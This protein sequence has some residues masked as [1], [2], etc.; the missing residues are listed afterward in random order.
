MDEI[1]KSEFN[2]FVTKFQSYFPDPQKP[3]KK[4]LAEPTQDEINELIAEILWRL[5]SPRDA[6][7]HHYYFL[8]R[9]IAHRSDCD[10]LK[11]YIASI[12]IWKC[13]SRPEKCTWE[14]HGRRTTSDGT[15]IYTCCCGIP[16]RSKGSSRFLI[17]ADE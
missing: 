3:S 11:R 6:E 12:P 4:R 5:P 15:K 10:K 2:E 14:S 17:P 16:Q 8:V 13:G 7:E 9:R 1:I